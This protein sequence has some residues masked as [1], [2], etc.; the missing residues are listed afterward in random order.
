MPTC[1]KCGEQ[2]SDYAPPEPTPIHKPVRTAHGMLEPTDG[3]TGT[4][5]AVVPPEPPEEEH[6]EVD[7]EVEEVEPDTGEVVKRTRKVKRPKPK[8]RRR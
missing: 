3:R 5:A 6:E 7:E 8:A 1:P 2:F 4:T